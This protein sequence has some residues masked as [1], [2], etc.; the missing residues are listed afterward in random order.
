MV[1]F[2]LHKYNFMESCFIFPPKGGCSPSEE[3]SSPNSAPDSSGEEVGQL[4]CSIEDLRLLSEE[5]L[6]GSAAPGEGQPEP[7]GGTLAKSNH[8]EETELSSAVPGEGQPEPGGGT[9]VGSTHDF[10]FHGEA[11][12]GSAVPGEEQSELGGGTQRWLPPDSGGGRRDSVG[13]DGGDPRQ[14][15]SDLL[16][17]R[18]ILTDSPRRAWRLLH[19]RLR[20]PR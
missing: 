9:S 7:G 13:S 2:L 18:R 17:N 6:L 19:L 8:G 20:S 3:G 12:V 11:V 16:S 4:R 5:T 1:K 14:T 10:D 15:R